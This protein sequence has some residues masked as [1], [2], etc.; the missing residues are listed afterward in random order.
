MQR[1]ANRGVVLMASFVR[2][3]GVA[4]RL[5]VCVVVG[6]TVAIAS[7]DGVAARGLGLGR[8]VKDAAAPS[9]KVAAVLHVGRLADLDAVACVSRYRC[10]AVGGYNKGALIAREVGS[11]W[12]QTKIVLGGNSLRD[13]LTGVSCVSETWCVAVGARYAGTEGV[14]FLIKGP[15][16]SIMPSPAGIAHYLLFGRVMYVEVLLRCGRSSER[17]GGVAAH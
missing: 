17:F 5:V 6:C 8:S 7:L 3:R 15:R 12:L 13:E 11:A 9:W 2:G 10:V 14:Q 4:V 1:R 16:W